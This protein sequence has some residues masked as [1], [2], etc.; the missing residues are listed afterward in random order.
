MRPGLL[1]TVAA[2]R[3]DIEAIG[4]G[5]RPWHAGFDLWRKARQD[6]QSGS[7]ERGNSDG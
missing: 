1:R 3:A 5:E 2:D 7:N 4:L 6:G